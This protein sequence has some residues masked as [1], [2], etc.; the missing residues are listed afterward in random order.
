MTASG[1]QLHLRAWMDAAPVADPL[2]G[3]SPLGVAAANPRPNN[4]CAAV[5]FLSHLL[6]LAHARGPWMAVAGHHRYDDAGGV[7]HGF[8]TG[9]PRHAPVQSI[10]IAGLQSRGLVWWFDD[11]SGLLA[12]VLEDGTALVHPAVLRMNAPPALCSVR[13]GADHTPPALVVRHATP[14]TLRKTMATLDSGLTGPLPHHTTGWHALLRAAV[15]R[16]DAVFDTDAPVLLP[17]HLTTNPTQWA[18]SGPRLGTPGIVAEVQRALDLTAAWLMAAAHQH[19]P[20]PPATLSIVRG[21]GYRCDMAT[22]AW[23]GQRPG[24]RNVAGP[25]WA[26]ILPTSL[27]HLLGP[28][29]HADVGL[30]YKRAERTNHWQGVDGHQLGTAH[31]QPTAHNVLAALHAYGDA[32]AEHQT[33]LQRIL[34]EMWA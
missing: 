11:N 34:P 29:L 19:A 32:T 26:R 30:A 28:A 1:P 5:G 17:P 10:P 12:R 4:G 21:A 22:V 31:A 20:R 33:Q 24:S 6:P 25:I 2:L 15:D 8:T 13:F 23:T 14:G 9:S 7:L 3:R 27:Y 18:P 16:M